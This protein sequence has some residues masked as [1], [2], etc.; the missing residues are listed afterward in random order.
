MLCT[1][2]FHASGEGFRVLT[3][4]ELAASHGFT[5]SAILPSFPKHI[6]T[7]PPCQLLLSSLEAIWPIRQPSI[8]DVIFQPIMH[9]F[10][11]TRTWI[12]ALRRYLLHDWIDASIITSTASKADDA[13]LPYHL[14]DNRL[15]LLFPGC[16]PHLDALRQTLLRWMRR[17]LVKEISQYL[18]E[19][20]GSHWVQD[21]QLARQWSRKALLHGD[22][23]GC[24][25]L[26]H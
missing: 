1:T 9:I 18:G 11:E 6:L 3:I 23:G 20:F 12:P 19:C 10:R 17:C 25:L 8:F 4:N 24:R 22:R 26:E 14:W 5:R 13:A 7:Y 15:E 21:L 2:Q 16:T